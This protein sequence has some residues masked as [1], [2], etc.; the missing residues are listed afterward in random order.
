[1][2]NG[3]VNAFVPAQPHLSVTSKHKNS[4][5]LI[6]LIFIVIV[7]ITLGFSYY[8]FRSLPGLDQGIAQPETIQQ[9]TK[10]ITVPQPPP[11]QQK[12]SDRLPQKT[13]S[14]DNPN[15]VKNLSERPPEKR[16]I[17][18]PQTAV[19]SIPLLKDLPFNLQASLPE[20]KFSGH[21]YSENPSLRMIM[22][23][24]AVLRE[25]DVVF[26]DITLLEITE[27]GLIMDYR[28][29]KFRHQLF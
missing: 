19:E 25:G 8:T 26:T 17:T 9:L 6:F 10:T 7:L 2:K 13:S 4:I 23:N 16:S 12:T 29:T 21:V 5:V 1:M 15:I 11:S 27:D 20:M 18:I 28:G 3:S 24:T 14:I 22:I